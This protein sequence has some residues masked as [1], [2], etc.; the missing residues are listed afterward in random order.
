VTVVGLKPPA[1]STVTF[2]AA[3]VSIVKRP[4]REQ[5]PVSGGQVIYTLLVRNAGPSDAT[6]V[7]VTIRWRRA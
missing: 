5:L 1:C 4:S 6:G 3:D 7:T 2:R